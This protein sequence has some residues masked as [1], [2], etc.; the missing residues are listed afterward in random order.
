MKKSGLVLICS[1]LFFLAGA[2]K[3]EALR[4]GR[5]LVLEGDRKIE[6]LASC[7]DPATID[8]WQETRRVRDFRWGRFWNVWE[9]VVVEE[10]TYNFG[11]RRFIQVIR[12][13]NG[14]VVK[15]E[16]GGYGF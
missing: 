13:E 8:T 3:S 4:C 14:R 5:D 12:F 16:D 10:W 7:G 9:T 15:I 6:V 2:V 11:P 1:M